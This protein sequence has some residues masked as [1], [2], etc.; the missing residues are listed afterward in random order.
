MQNLHEGNFK[1]HQKD[2][3]LNLNEWEDTPCF[4]IKDSTLTELGN[5]GI[6]S[7][8]NWRKQEFHFDC[9]DFDPSG[10]RLYEHWIDER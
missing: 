2:Y 10:E 9:T 5:T 8:E 3:K 4:L 1:V 7:F 6:R